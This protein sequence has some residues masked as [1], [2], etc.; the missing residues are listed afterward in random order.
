MSKAFLDRLL[1]PQVVN[2]LFTVTKHGD[3]L[4]MYKLLMSFISSF[5]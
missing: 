2:K 3:S 5:T 1:F 4:V